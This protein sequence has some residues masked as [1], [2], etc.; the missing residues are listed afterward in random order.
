LGPQEN[1]DNEVV[2]MADQLEVGQIVRS[3]IIAPGG[4]DSH[5]S[6]DIKSWSATID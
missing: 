2:D 4:V 5:V 3:M 6:G 1:Q